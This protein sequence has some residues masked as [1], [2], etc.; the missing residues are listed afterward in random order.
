MVL[1]GGEYAF[2]YKVCQP[3]IYIDISNFPPFPKEECKRPKYNLDKLELEPP[4]PPSCPMT[5]NKDS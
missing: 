3:S 2:W 4:Q 1:C 5:Q